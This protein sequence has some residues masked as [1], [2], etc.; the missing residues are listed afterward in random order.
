[1]SIYNNIYKLAK[2]FLKMSKPVGLVNSLSEAAQ[3]LGISESA[4]KKEIDQAYR[5]KALQHHPDKNPGK[6]TTLLMQKINEAREFFLDYLNN[7]SQPPQI[8]EPI[9]DPIEDPMYS[10][11]EDVAEEYKQDRDAWS[12]KYNKYEVQ[13]EIGIDAWNSMFEGYDPNYEP[14]PE[15]QMKEDQIYD[16]IF[17]SLKDEIDIDNVI[18]FWFENKNLQHLTKEKIK[19]FIKNHDI[20]ELKEII[21]LS[22]YN[23]AKKKLLSQFRESTI[24]K[25]ETFVIT[26]LIESL[27]KE[28]LLLK[29]ITPAEILSG[30]FFNYQLAFK[31]LMNMPEEQFMELINKIK[32]SPEKFIKNEWGFNK[33][34]NCSIAFNGPNA[35]ELG[36]TL[37]NAINWRSK[38]KGD[39]RYYD[40]YMESD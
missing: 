21:D 36:R 10:S 39:R 32:N 34:I 33:E 2:L 29:I 4:D 40:K 25:V 20:N 1:M 30:E 16:Y 37:R 26:S 11:W 22:G 7:S 18:D 28:D 31:V 24:K 5:R 8:M 9:E 38:D 3:I 23:G 15:Q 12:K 19:K 27:I 13:G 14:G 17:E 35:E 6:D